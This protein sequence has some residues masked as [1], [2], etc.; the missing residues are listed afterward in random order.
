MKSYFVKPSLNYMPFTAMFPPHT[1]E[2]QAQAVKYMKS[3]RTTQARCCKCFWFWTVFLVVGILAIIFRQNIGDLFNKELDNA[4]TPAI[5]KSSKSATSLLDLSDTLNH[6]HSNYD[7]LLANTEIMLEKWQ[8]QINQN[9]EQMQTLYELKQQNKELEMRYKEAMAK[10]N[11][12]W[13]ITEEK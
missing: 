1:P 3:G 8:K 13:L 4:K 2:E 11:I 12:V 9:Q 6:S 10:E 7:H 5:D